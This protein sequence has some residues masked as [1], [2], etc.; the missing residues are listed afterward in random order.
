MWG[1][2]PTRESRNIL[3]V[4]GWRS[5]G[6]AEQSVNFGYGAF[7]DLRPSVLKAG[8]VDI[9]PRTRDMHDRS[10]RLFGGTVCTHH[11]IRLNNTEMRCQTFTQLRF[12]H[13]K[14]TGV[15]SVIATSPSKNCSFGGLCPCIHLGLRRAC[16]G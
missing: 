4:R 11:A 6:T 12:N 15:S 2:M 10:R 3:T 13:F 14:R 5:D 16:V 8:C 7:C 1:P 9:D